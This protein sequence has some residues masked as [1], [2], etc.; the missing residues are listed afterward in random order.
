MHPWGMRMSRSSRDGMWG[1]RGQGSPPERASVPAV[2]VIALVVAAALVGVVLQLGVLSLPAVPVPS[3]SVAEISVDA[4]TLP[5]R[6]VSY[7]AWDVEESPEYVRVV[8]PAVVDVDIPVGEVW[9]APLDA[10]GRTRRAAGAIDLKTM[11]AGRARER[12]DL[13]GHD[14]SGWGSNAETDIPLPDGSS[15]HGFFW[16]RSHLVAKSLGGSD[17]VE[18]L[19]CATRMENVGANDGKG[20]MSYAE[21]MVRAW[22]SDNPDGWVFYSAT[23]AYESNELVCRSVIVDV[24]SSDGTLDFEVEVYNAALGHEVD[25]Q[26][27]AF[28]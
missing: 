17:E 28:S 18:N 2:V 15:Y 1:G 27:G 23:P 21:G 8:G 9:Y 3:A 24:R 19:V 14:P 7:T 22:L 10:L 5:L 4:T 13:R 11:E 6:E 12:G 20:G 26:T 25:Y 16:N